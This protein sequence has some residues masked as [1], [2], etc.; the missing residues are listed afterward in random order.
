MKIILVKKNGIPVTIGVGRYSF[1]IE[2]GKLVQDEC[3]RIGALT[4]TGDTTAFLEAWGLAQWAWENQVWDSV[5][6]HN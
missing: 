6:E 2:Q 5:E 3:Q 4:T 1:G